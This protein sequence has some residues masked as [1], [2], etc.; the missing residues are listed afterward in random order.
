MQ[1]AR[2][3]QPAGARRICGPPSGCT[4]QCRGEHITGGHARCLVISIGD[5][6]TATRKQNRS[7]SGHLDEHSIRKTARGMMRRGTISRMPTVCPFTARAHSHPRR[8]LCLSC[9]AHCFGIHVLLAT[10]ALGRDCGKRRCGAMR[11][12]SRRNG[13]ASGFA[14]P[15]A[16]PSGSRLCGQWCA[17]PPPPPPPPPPTLPRPHSSL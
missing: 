15:R 14:K 3:V 16:R 2:K 10:L 12:R 1:R 13:G 4:G 9:H 7:A 11:L 6:D 8:P 17:G 5:N